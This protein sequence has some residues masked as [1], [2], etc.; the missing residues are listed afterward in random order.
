MAHNSCQSGLEA[1]VWDLRT[2]LSVSGQL[3]CSNPGVSQKRLAPESRIVLQQVVDIPNPIILFS[4]TDAFRF[5][6]LHIV[7]DGRSV[8][9]WNRKA[10]RVDSDRFSRV[11][12]TRRLAIHRNTGSGSTSIPD[13]GKLGQTEESKFFG[14]PYTQSYRRRGRKDKRSE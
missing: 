2:Q 9:A 6:V 5:P 12:N 10:R 8:D 1:K 4:R 14:V 11:Q 7:G 13:L 3:T